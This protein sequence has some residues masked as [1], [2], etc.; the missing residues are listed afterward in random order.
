MGAYMSID[1]HMHSTRLANDM[2]I[3]FLIGI[4]PPLDASCV[5]ASTCINQSI[6]S[7]LQSI[8]AELLP[9]I[10]HCYSLIGIGIHQHSCGLF[11]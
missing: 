5:S 1:K 10:R 2:M 9:S 8:I 6:V 11:F 3:S 4:E 7:I